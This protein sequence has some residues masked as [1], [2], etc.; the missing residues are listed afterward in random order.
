[1]AARKLS[2]GQALTLE[3]FND[4][5][6]SVQAIEKANVQDILLGYKIK[7]VDRRLNQIAVVADTVAK[8]WTAKQSEDT[9]TVKLGKMFKGAPVVTMSVKV[10][11]ESSVPL[12]A[13]LKE[14]SAQDFKVKLFLP[15]EFAKKGVKRF[16]YEVSFI[17]IGVERD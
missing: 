2:P 6:S 3:I 5:V 16:N 13:I 14:V 1:M 8:Q 7:G 4:L 17:A 11:S 9:V 15:E 12:I 10:K